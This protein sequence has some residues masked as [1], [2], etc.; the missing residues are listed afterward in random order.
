MGEVLEEEV[1]IVEFK[2]ELSEIETKIFIDV[3]GG[4]SRQYILASI[5]EK[6]PK[7][8]KSDLGKKVDFVMGAWKHYRGRKTR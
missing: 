3:I 4:Y 7:M 8:K 6:Y 2:K 5:H 1:L